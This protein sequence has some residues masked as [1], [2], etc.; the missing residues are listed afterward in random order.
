MTFIGAD[1][2][3]APLLRELP[4]DDSEDFYDKLTDE[5][6]ALYQKAGLVHGDLSEYNIMVWE[7]KPVIFDLSQ[8]MLTIHPLAPSLLQHDV[9]TINAYFA[10]LGVEVY[11]NKELE[12]WVKS[13]EA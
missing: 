7:K 4:L 11:D 2:V 5:M 1:G 6:R 9:E 8:A 10:K 12:E 3:P 13:G